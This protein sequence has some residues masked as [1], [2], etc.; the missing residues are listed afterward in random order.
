M[1]IPLNPLGDN[2]E[3]PGAPVDPADLRSVWEMLREVQARRPG[4]HF[5]IGDEMY[6]RACSPGAD[7][8]AVWFRASIIAMLDL[9]GM[10]KRWINEGVV[11]D[12]VFT[13]AANFPMNGMATRVPRQGLPFDVQEFMSQVASSAG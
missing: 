7:V 8:G 1:E 2:P 9:L 4:A 3:G 11:T 13:V 5:I 12:A 6:K 10:L